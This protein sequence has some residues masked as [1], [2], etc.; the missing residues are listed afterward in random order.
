[1][2]IVIKLRDGDAGHVQIEE[3]RYFASGET[4]TSVTVASAL[5]EEMLTLIGKLGEAE[6]L[7]ASED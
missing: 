4:E 2:K 7:P 3:E 6:A 1:M 5:A